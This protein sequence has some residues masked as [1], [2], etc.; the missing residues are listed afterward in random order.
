M[1]PDPC[2]RSQRL[3]R[4]CGFA[5]VVRRFAQLACVAACVL[6]AQYAFSQ[7]RACTHDPNSFQ[8]A[9]TPI[10]QARCLLRR[11][12]IGG[13]LSSE[14]ADLPTNLEKLIGQDVKISRSQLRKYLQ[15][16]AVDEADLG[17]SLDDPLAKSRLKYG[18]EMQSVYFVIHDT[19]SPY[20]GDSPFP[21]D[22]DTNSEWKGNDLKQWVD[23][24][25]AHVFVNRLGSSITTT[26]FS[27]A[28]KKGWGTKFARDILKSDGKGTQIHIELV[29]PRRRDPR[30]ANL[31]NDRIAP[32]P[33]FTDAQ[34]Q[35]LALLYLCASLRRGTWMI[36]AYHSAIDAGI[37]DAHDDPQN[38]D[39]KAFAKQ[40]S[41]LIRKIG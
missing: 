29:Q 18:K 21:A 7:N 31:K 10:E 17:G 40:L 35:R 16:A 36:P 22:M 33:G 3:F 32:V 9:G 11:N 8:F 5:L 1:H 38:F 2:Q 25:V 4:V 12:S 19:S 41:N 30:D 13:I 28:V 24:P 15:K 6:L 14:D 27:E 37:K 20:L 26:P 34:Y 39:L 23:Q